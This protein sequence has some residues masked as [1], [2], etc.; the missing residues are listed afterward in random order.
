M[1]G[2]ARDWASLVEGPEGL[3]VEQV[4]PHVLRLGERAV[5]APERSWFYLVSG[6][7]CDCL[8]DGGWGFCNRL[9]GLRSDPGKPL[10]S[11]A[12]HTHFDHVGLLHLAAS[13]HVHPSELDILRD[14][15]PF[16]TQALPYLDGRPV[17]ANGGTI[18]PG[19]IRQAPVSVLI[20]IRDGD[21][22]DIGGRHLDILHTPG[23]SPGSLS[24]LD[25]AGGLLFCA[26]TVHDGHIWDDIPGADPA[27]L[28]LSHERLAWVEFAQACPGHG[29]LLSPS[30]FAARM[31][32]HRRERTI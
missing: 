15:D 21:T 5:S 1:T 17:L 4:A 30:E 6:D 12:T 19:S 24:I 3:I 29:A 27:A 10:V 14:P 31:D 7:D 20:P 9:D 11:I 16:E 2:A 22:L 32:R 25:A 26:D 13:V 18:A 23:H 8:I 28:L